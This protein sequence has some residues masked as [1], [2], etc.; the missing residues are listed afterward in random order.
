MAQGGGAQPPAAGPQQQDG[1]VFPIFYSYPPYYT[2]QPVKETQQKQRLLWRDLILRYCRH[3]RIHV[4]PAGETDDFPLFH[5]AGIN[6]RLSRE[7]KVLFLD[8]LVK[9]GS[10]LW[11]DK[12]QRS[13]LVLWRSIAEWAD[14]IYT[15]ARANGLEDS[16]VTVDEMQ[17]GV[18]VAGTELEGL[19]REVLVR[20]VRHLEQQ[21]R[22]KL[23]KGAAGDDE[24]IKF[25]PG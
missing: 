20:A 8:D 15:W 11:F 5:N 22:A 23:F 9:A 18:Y 12:S 13:A 17:T 7:M 1:F 21:G 4:V 24:G 14:A 25:F 10:A 6:R 3:H 16:V 2:L 19:H